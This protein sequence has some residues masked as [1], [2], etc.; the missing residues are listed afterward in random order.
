VG[1]VQ[2]L[3]FLRITPHVRVVEL[4]HPFISRLYPG[5]LT[6]GAQIIPVEIEDF[7]AVFFTLAKPQAGFPVWLDAVRINIFVV[8]FLKQKERGKAF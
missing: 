7:Q 4:G 8:V 5:H 3:E 6:I 1:I 2:L